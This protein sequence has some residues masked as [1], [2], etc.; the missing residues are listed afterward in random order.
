VSRNVC[1]IACAY[2]PAY[3]R[4]ESR[5]KSIDEMHISIGGTPLRGRREVRLVA[6]RSL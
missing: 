6:D 4:V 2:S 3:R 1:L 5:E